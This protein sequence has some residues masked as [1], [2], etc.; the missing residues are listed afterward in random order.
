MQYQVWGGEKVRKDKKLRE[1]LKNATAIL[2]KGYII[3]GNKDP[4][5]SYTGVAMDP[6]EK[7]VQ[8]ADDF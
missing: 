6:F 7:P 3:P 5:G 2:P 8:D 1:T 4:L